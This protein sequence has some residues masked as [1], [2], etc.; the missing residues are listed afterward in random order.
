MVV[1]SRPHRPPRLRVAA[2]LAALFVLVLAPS[3]A[4]AQFSEVIHRYDVTLT[5]RPDGSLQVE[6]RIQYDF[7]DTPHHGITR[8]IPDRFH[9]DDRYDRSEPISGIK[10]TATDAS[11]KTKVGRNGADAEI[12]IGDADK[13]ITG[14]HLYT[15]SYLVRGALNNFPD[16]VELYWNAI[17]TEWS[18]PIEEASARVSA[19]AAIQRVACFAGP[20]GSNLSC[21]RSSVEGDTATFAQPGGLNASEGLSVVV[22]IPP[23]AV[24]TPA[25][26][27][28]ERFSLSRAFAVTPASL[29]LTAL[30]ALLFFG[31]IGRLLWT[32][33]RDVRY[34]GSVVDASYGG[35]EGERRVALFERG[36]V[37][38]E[39]QPPEGIKPG[40]VGTLVDE[41]ANPL[42]VTASIVDLGVRGYL[43]IEE[44]PKKHF[45]GKPDWWLIQLRVPDEELLRYERTLLSGLFED[46]SDEDLAEAS[47]APERPDLPPGTPRHDGIAAVKLSKL[48]TK[49]VSRLRDVEDQLY[50]D[51]VERGWFSMRP[52]KVRVTWH[53][54]AIGLLVLGGVLTFALAKLTHF[55]LVGIP[56]ALSGI[57]LLFGAHAMP[58]RTAKGTAMVRRIQGFRTYIETAE[59]QEAKFQEQE[60][61]FSR[62]LPYAIVFGAVEKWAQRFEGLDQQAANVGWYAGSHPFTAVGFSQAMDSF[63]VTTSGTISS[64]PSSSGGSGFGGGGSSGGGGGGGGGG[65]W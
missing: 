17:G 37:P 34:A 50:T 64:T 56:V 1:P 55:G 45:W 15:I 8:E 53:G 14:S 2:A 42:D 35:S 38:V 32:R 24:P 57:F 40:Q 12:R 25:P 36:A 54:R 16:H 46:A 31:W 20:L 13:T 61:L 23:G 9:Y 62:Y 26:I 41:S 58:R 44:I 7:G 3:A 11:A 21:S 28:K 4:R 22:A 29:G 63:T 6:E 19:P 65:S 18:V 52:D 39:Y 27:L 59:V 33:G 49:F 60:N 30:A 47:T 5:V 43:R 10:V 51:S 48:K